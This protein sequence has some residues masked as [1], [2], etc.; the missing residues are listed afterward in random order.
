MEVSVDETTLKGTLKV[1]T[2]NEPFGVNGAGEHYN[3][4]GKNI[5]VS[6]VKGDTSP[7]KS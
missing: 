2:V 5:M 7:I 4:A 1:A 6:E 3:V